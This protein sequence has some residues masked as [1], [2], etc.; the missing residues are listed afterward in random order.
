MLK[1]LKSKAFNRWRNMMDHRKFRIRVHSEDERISRSSNT[2]KRFFKEPESSFDSMH[3]HDAINL[4][5]R[6]AK[7]ETSK[8]EISEPSDIYEKEADRI[9]DTV[10]NM[11]DAEVQMKS[12]TVAMETSSKPVQRKDG[13]NTMVV[14]QNIN[15]EISSLKGSGTPLSQGERKFYEARFNRDFSTVRVHTGSKADYLARSINARAFTHGSNIVFAKGQYNSASREG[16]K[17]MAHELAHTAQQGAGIQKKDKIYRKIYIYSGGQLSWESRRHNFKVFGYH[18]DSL[19][20]DR[21]YVIRDTFL[22][23]LPIVSYFSKKRELLGYLIKRDASSYSIY[24]MEGKLYSRFPLSHF[25]QKEKQTALRLAWGHLIVDVVGDIFLI[26]KIGKIVKLT[27]STKGI[28]A[29]IAREYGYEGDPGALVK[30]KEFQ[31][32][33]SLLKSFAGTLPGVGSVISAYDLIQVM[34][35]ETKDYIK[36]NGNKL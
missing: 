21:L 5:F 22:S 26:G 30:L 11:S 8:L 13:S 20:G 12:N 25:V 18:R 1:L 3:H 31:K 15:S 9:A 14:G 23:K 34:G 27:G 36:T 16:K 6:Q 28:A 17:L 33:K 32:D 35:T 2:T 24:T 29:Q 10:V 19:V 4:I 7:K